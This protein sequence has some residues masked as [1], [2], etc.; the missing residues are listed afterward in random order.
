[1]GIL[2]TKILLP[3]TQHDF[4]FYCRYGNGNTEGIRHSYGVIVN[5]SASTGKFFYHAFT[6]DDKP[7]FKYIGASD[8][9]FTS[10]LEEA[11]RIVDEAL[12]KVGWRLLNEGDK[13]L[14]LV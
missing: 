12:T 11:K 2:M 7:I 3:W 5:D 14:T 4:L 9:D 8:S 13:L 1:M 10:S 6:L